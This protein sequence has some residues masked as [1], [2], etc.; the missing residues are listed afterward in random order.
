MP[1]NLRI[2]VI[3]CGLG[4]ATATIFL[5]RQGYQVE[6]YEQSH[7]LKRIGAGISLG[8]NVLR[9][10]RE[11]S[12]AESFLKTGT[13]PRTRLSREWNTGAILNEMDLEHERKRYGEVMMSMHRGDMLQLLV[14]AVEP[15]TVRFGKRAV[16][17]DNAPGGGVR[18]TFDDGTVAEADLVIGAD[19]VNS[20][21]REILQGAEPPVFTGTVA[22]RSIFPVS[23]LGDF[24]PKAD[25]TKWWTTDSYPAGEDRHFIVY[26]LTNRRDEIYFVTGS[27]APDWD[28]SQSSVPVDV[29]EIKECYAGFHPEVQKII[30]ACPAATKWPLL[31][32]KPLTVWGTDNVVLLGDACHPMK[33]HMGQGAGMAIEDAAILARCLQQ[34]SNVKDALQIYQYNRRERTALVQEHSRKNTWLKYPTDTSWV[35]G[36][37]A[38][39]IPLRIPEG[40]QAA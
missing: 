29:N 17:I 25:T 8:P 31:E 9:I 7:E 18:V 13:V 34:S 12:L 4:G 15:N 28:P 3:G 32:R 40:I 38:I 14:D 35:Y 16:G 23:R 22:Y 21:I 24:R 27:P 1:A 5:Q 19:G 36:Y 10:V 30:D 33:P 6:V 11:L 20:T 37:D 26:Y 39:R 2:I